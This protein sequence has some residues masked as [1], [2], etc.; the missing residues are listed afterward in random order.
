MFPPELLLIKIVINCHNYCPILQL[1]LAAG[2]KFRKTYFLEGLNELPGP[3]L[4]K[5]GD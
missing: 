5:I 1:K 4:I 2:I 3:K